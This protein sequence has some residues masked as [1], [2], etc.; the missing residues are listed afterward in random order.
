CGLELDADYNASLNHQHD[1][2]DIPHA[3]RKLNLNRKGFF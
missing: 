1:L 2:P 3:L